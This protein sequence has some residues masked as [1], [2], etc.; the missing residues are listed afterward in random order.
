LQKLLALLDKGSFKGAPFKRLASSSG[1]ESEVVQ[2]EVTGKLFRSIREQYLQNNI[3]IASMLTQIA[4][5]LS[6]NDHN[7]MA[8]IKST[9]GNEI[10]RLHTNARSSLMKIDVGI[11][12]AFVGLGMQHIAHVFERLVRSN[13]FTLQSQSLAT[14]LLDIAQEIAEYQD[15]RGINSLYNLS[16]QPLSL[17]TCQISQCVCN[18]CLSVP[19]S[20]C[21]QVFVQCFA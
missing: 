8:L 17:S 16:L 18:T 10:C 1:W 7:R 14:Q 4:F 13:Q 11:D 2:D 21:R 20:G 6:A 3:E 19:M 15:E 12:E 5:K 9:V